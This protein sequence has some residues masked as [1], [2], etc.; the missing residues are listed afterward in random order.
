[1][2][3]DQPFAFDEQ[4]QLSKDASATLHPSGALAIKTKHN[5]VT[6]DASETWNLLQWLAD[7]QRERLYQ[8][9]Q[10]SGQ[11]EKGPNQ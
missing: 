8:L 11:A 4:T 9:V 10:H 6:L 2:T 1:M 7:H 5:Q 3:E